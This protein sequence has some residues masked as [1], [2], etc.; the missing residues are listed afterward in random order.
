MN[1]WVQDSSRKV[2]RERREEEKRKIRQEREAARDFSERVSPE[3]CPLHFGHRELAVLGSAGHFVSFDEIL[4]LITFDGT[5][6]LTQGQC[7]LT[8]RKSWDVF[9]TVDYLGD[10]ETSQMRREEEIKAKD[11]SEKRGHHMSCQ[12]IYRVLQCHGTAGI[13]QWTLATTPSVS[14]CVV[15]SSNGCHGLLS[16]DDETRDQRDERQSQ[17]GTEYLEML[18]SNYLHLYRYKSQLPRTSASAGHSG[19]IDPCLVSIKLRGSTSACLRLGMKAA[20]IPMPWQTTNIEK[21]GIMI[22]SRCPSRRPG[23]Y[24]DST[25]MQIQVAALPNPGVNQR[26]HR[27]S[28]PKTTS[29]WTDKGFN[30]GFA[31]L[32]NVLYDC[33]D[34]QPI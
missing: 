10:S 28:A 32:L 19:W 21:L 15:R 9:P 18:R 31:V 13:L 34:S 23:P 17:L 30:H 20:H 25:L 29:C 7:V 3:P 5:L 16:G 2:L 24:T 22:V 12:A 33:L 26:R 14:D 27:R 8:S 1:S 6:R 11:S 4:V